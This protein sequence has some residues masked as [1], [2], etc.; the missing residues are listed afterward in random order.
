MVGLGPG[1]DLEREFESEGPGIIGVHVQ[2][3]GGG[4]AWPWR[5]QGRRSG[6]KRIRRN[7]NIQR[8]L[9]LRELLARVSTGLREV[10]LT[11]RTKLD[12]RQLLGISVESL[13]CYH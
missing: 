6:E 7:Y 5:A 2:L 4:C 1:E 3:F 13:L 10:K 11:C 12:P 9:R 8:G